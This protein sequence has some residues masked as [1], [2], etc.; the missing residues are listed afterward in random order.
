MKHKDTPRTNLFLK[1]L[2]GASPLVRANN[3]VYFARKLERELNKKP[4]P[5]RKI[6]YVHENTLQSP[7]YC[8]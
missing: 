4:R 7:R 3:L 1:Q 2:D 8:L 5:R 6:V